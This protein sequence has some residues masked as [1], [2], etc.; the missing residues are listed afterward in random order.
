MRRLKGGSRDEEAGRQM[1]LPNKKGRT[2]SERP[3]DGHAGPPVFRLTH[4]MVDF[5]GLVSYVAVDKE[6]EF[7]KVAN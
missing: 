6:G 7:G 4:Q 2:R 3:A 5:G 1:A